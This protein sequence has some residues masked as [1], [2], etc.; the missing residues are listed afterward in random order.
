MWQKSLSHSINSTYKRQL[1]QRAIIQNKLFNQGQILSTRY[2]SLDLNPFL[3]C[4][5]NFRYYSKPANSTATEPLV[6]PISVINRNPD[7]NISISK[8]AAE[9]LGQIHNDSQEAL[10]LKV[11]SGGCHGFQYSLGLEPEDNSSTTN[12]KKSA[13]LGN[14]DEIQDEFTDEFDD[15]FDD[16]KLNPEITYILPS[17]AKIKMDQN[18][19]KIL[20]NTCL[21]YTTEL[22]GSSFKITGGSLKSPCGCGSSFDVEE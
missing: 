5:N 6:E 14:D 21:T 1:L 11:E 8:S 9:R 2:Y 7:L 12:G 22:I 20:N 4:K 18:T 17:G 19:L 15:E 13:Q 16:A 10:R 3:S